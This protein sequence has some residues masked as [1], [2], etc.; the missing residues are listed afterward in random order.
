MM[1]YLVI[2]ISLL[3]CLSCQ[4]DGAKQITE[5]TEEKEEVQQEGLRNVAG[6]P[7]GT[8]QEATQ[9]LAGAQAK[10]KE[11]NKRMTEMIKENKGREILE[12]GEPLTAL[13][14]MMT[15]MDSLTQRLVEG[16]EIDFL[17]DRDRGK[18]ERRQQTNL[19][20]LI[21]SLNHM[22]NL[23]D[24]ILRKSDERLMQE[25]KNNK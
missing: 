21:D 19:D 7:I 20:A 13:R 17:S 25:M 22:N 12:I 9:L 10:S 15:R 1:K 6:Y 14:P 5:P 18:I 24:L 2:T 23:L 4:N 8:M 3:F 11:L 16:K